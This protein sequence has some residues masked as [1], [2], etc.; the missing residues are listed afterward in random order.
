MICLAGSGLAMC[1]KKSESGVAPPSDIPGLFCLHD[2]RAAGCA[3]LWHDDKLF[4]HIRGDNHPSV[5]LRDGLGNN[6]RREGEEEN[7]CAKHVEFGRG[8]GLPQYQ[9][10]VESWERDKHAYVGR[11]SCLDV[12]FP[13]QFGPVQLLN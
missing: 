9:Q 13:A 12:L 10:Q 7:G 4:V 11:P 6:S 8:D 1:G 3:G 2:C 5:A